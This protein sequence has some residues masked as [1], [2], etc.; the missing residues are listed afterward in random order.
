MVIWVDVPVVIVIKAPNCKKMSKRVSNSLFRTY[1]EIP[2]AYFNKV[3]H[4][5]EPVVNPR[6]KAYAA[7]KRQAYRKHK[8]DAY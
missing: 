5:L 8:K 6:G 1:G 4:K 2:V 3:T 7:R